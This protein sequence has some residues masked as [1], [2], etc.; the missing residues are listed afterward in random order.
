MSLKK[1]A[2]LL[3]LSSLLLLQGCST[4]SSSNT[5]TEDS[6]N[7]SDSKEDSSESSESESNSSEDS[8]LSDS[9]EEESASQEVF[10][11]DT[12]MTVTAYGDNKDQAVEDAV[13]EINRLDSLLSTG[14][15]SSEIAQINA[16]GGGTLSE[17]GAYLMKKSIQLNQDTDE[18]FDV[19][20]YPLMQE[21]GF[22]SGNYKV[23]DDSTIQNLLT[24]TDASNIEYDESTSTVSFKKEGM[25]IDFGGIAKGYTSS[26]IMDIYKEDG[27]TSGLV[28]LGGNVQVLGSKP[29][30]SDW[31]VAIQSPDDSE[32]MLGVLSVSDC[33]VITSGGYERYFEEDGK[34]YHHIIDPRTGYPADSGLIST[35]V[36]SQDGTLADGL[37]TSLFIMGKDKA[38]EFWREHSDEFQAV[39]CDENNTLWVTEGIADS[40][41]SD[42]DIQVISLS[43]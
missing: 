32:D 18:L 25:A 42:Y 22:T 37:S 40:F 41:T 7:S 12:V 5:A 1:I 28:N 20:I 43:E 14:N 11:M 19:A 33:A 36:I 3:G 39:L 26:K 9:G 30:G 16:N 27:I 21:W 29:D 24:L 4:G 35:T 13:T 34:T 17:D 15:E 8:S 23:P 6:A 10:A 2:V 38:I 31:R